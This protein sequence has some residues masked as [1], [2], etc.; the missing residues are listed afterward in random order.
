MSQ[1]LECA[2]KLNFKLYLNF[3][4]ANHFSLG[5]YLRFLCAFKYLI[6]STQSFGK[7]TNEI[8]FDLILPGSFKILEAS[9]YQKGLR[10]VKVMEIKLQIV[11]GYFLGYKANKN[12][13]QLFTKSTLEEE[14]GSA[15]PLRNN[16]FD[17]LMRLNFGGL[18]QP[19]KLK[20]SREYNFADSLLSD[21]LQ[22]WL[23]E[24]TP[25]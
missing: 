12:R 13:W 7:M 17:T 18:P 5:Y 8:L 6:S 4:E 21:F 25:K 19:R 2:F 23:R 11:I 15:H 10:K 20:I 14:S 24:R 1:T 16:F 3:H 9:Y 22:T